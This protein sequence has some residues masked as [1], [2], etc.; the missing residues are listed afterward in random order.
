MG[1]D[2]RRVIK[3]DFKLEKVMAKRAKIKEQ[4]LIR[5]RKNVRA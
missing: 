4:E 3:R 5:Q 2:V 1:F